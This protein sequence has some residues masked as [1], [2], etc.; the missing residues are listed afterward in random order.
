MVAF[1]LL[2]L[3]VFMVCLAAASRF[4]EQRQKSMVAAEQLHTKR[5]RDGT[6]R[7]HGTEE[8]QLGLVTTGGGELQANDA[9]E[10]RR[11]LTKL[12]LGCYMDAFLEHGYDYWTEVRRLPSDRFAVLVHVTGMSIN[13]SH[14]L[15]E[16]RAAQREAMGIQ[17]VTSAATRAKSD[18]A[19]RIL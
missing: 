15:R 9:D 19:C 13:H 6:C 3:L 8:E 14:R 7:S 5:V 12:R 2:Q 10:V 16:Q 18:G 4:L 11:E 17:Q 1:A